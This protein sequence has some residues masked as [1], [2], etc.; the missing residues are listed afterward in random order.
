MNLIQQ[1]IY[2]DNNVKMLYV[3]EIWIQNNDIIS[4]IT[5]EKYELIL[6]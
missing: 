3:F 2:L 6:N 5:I 4:Y 1:I